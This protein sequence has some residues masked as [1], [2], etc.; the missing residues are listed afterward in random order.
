MRVRKTDVFARWI[1]S[2]RDMQARARIQ[3]RIERVMPGTLATSSLSAE[4]FLNY[5]SIRVRDIA[6]T[7]NSGELS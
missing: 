4:A 5:V 6:F 7:S 2:L 1:D 3:A